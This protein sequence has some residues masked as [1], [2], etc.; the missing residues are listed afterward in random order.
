VIKFDATTP[1][2]IDRDVAVTVTLRFKESELLA[3]AKAHCLASFLGGEFK[4]AIE[5]DYESDPYPALE[6]A[7]ISRD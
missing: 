7:G 1:P 6:L 4:S 2:V 3:E 5:G